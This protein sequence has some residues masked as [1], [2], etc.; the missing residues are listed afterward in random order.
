MITGS[1]NV[2]VNVALTNKFLMV[3]W[4]RKSIVYLYNYHTILWLKLLVLRRP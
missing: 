4:F 3:P 2:N 1:L